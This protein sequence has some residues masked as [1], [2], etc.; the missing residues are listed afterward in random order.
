MEL[1]IIDPTVSEFYEGQNNTGENSGFDLYL[2]ADYVFPAGATIMVHFG[3]SG[4]TVDGSGYWLMPRSSI[5]KTSLRFAN[6]LGLIDPSYRGSLIAAIWNPTNNDIS[7]ARGTRLVQIALPSLMPFRVSWVE[8]L[9]NT[10]RGSG[11]FGSTGQ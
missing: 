11:G 1:S 4:K 7:I 5:S 6:S 3:V 9:N 2:P 10:S 8:K